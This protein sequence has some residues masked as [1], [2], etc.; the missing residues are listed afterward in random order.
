ML[1]TYVSLALI[2]GASFIVGQAVFCAC[3]RPD[4][5]PLAPAVGLAL[6]CAVAWLAADLASSAWAGLG[7]VAVLTL[8]GAALLRLKGAAGAWDE[9][10]SAAIGAV[11]LGSLPF[12][13][14]MRFGIMGTSLNPDMSQ[15]LFAT[16]RIDGGGAER[17]ITE[18]YPLGP[19]ALVASVAKLGPSFVHGFNGLLLAT[20]VAATLA[21]LGALKRMERTRQIAVALLVG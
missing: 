1:G 8:A 13:I 19:H 20:A 5:S 7:G 16:D 3:G 6:L 11:V 15:H 9:I 14:E 18:G 2:L 10:P 21:P 4:R 17:L 12:M